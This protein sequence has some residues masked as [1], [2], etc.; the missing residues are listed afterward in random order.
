VDPEISI[1][2][3]APEELRGVVIDIAYEAGLDPHDMRSLVCRVLRRREDPDN[4]SAFPNVDGEVR[5]HLDS[6]Q[7][8][9][10]YDVIEAIWS[11]LKKQ[12]DKNIFSTEAEMF[13]PD[14]YEAFA[15]EVN[16]YFRC[17]NGRR[18]H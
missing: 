6:C 17:T 8:F 3:D 5:G 15:A 7:W 4:W 10:V 18:S 2:E 9:E 14:P 12:R 16:R 13:E 1:R 11:K